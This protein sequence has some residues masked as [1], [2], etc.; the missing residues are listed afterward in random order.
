[1]VTTMMRVPLSSSAASTPDF[2]VSPALRMAS[3]SMVATYAGV[4]LDLTHGLLQLVVEHGAVGDDD[5]RV[6]HRLVVLVVQTGQAVG[7]PGDR[8]G[9]ARAGGVLHE[10]AVAGTFGAAGLDELRHDVPLVHAREAHGRRGRLL[11]GDRV[12]P[13]LVLDEHELAEEV[14]PGVALEHALPQVGRLRAVRVERVARAAVDA[15]VER[16]EVRPRPGELGGHVD[17]GIRHR[18][19]HDRTRDRRQQRLVT[20]VAGRCGT[21][22]WRRRPT[23]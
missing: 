10:V 21:A 4:L 8:V 19:V 7:G 5:D 2:D 3:S 22:R 23:G 17:L 9:L 6:E 16:Q 12:D 1:M 13:L 18:E 15:E 14:E 20:G 11:P